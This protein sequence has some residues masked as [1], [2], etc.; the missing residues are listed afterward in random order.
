MIFK[1]E[2]MLVVFR[3]DLLLADY[4]LVLALLQMDIYGMDELRMVVIFA[5]DLNGVKNVVYFLTLVVSEL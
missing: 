2:N 3:K 4:V 1:E 5:T